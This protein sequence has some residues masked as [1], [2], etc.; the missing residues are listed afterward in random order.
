MPSPMTPA[1]NSGISH[2]LKQDG[3]RVIQNVNQDGNQSLQQLADRQRD[4]SHRY[5]DQ[6]VDAC[7]GRALGYREP[8]VADVILQC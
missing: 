3:Q 1:T 5:D 2:Q 7:A 6:V 4:H 8:L